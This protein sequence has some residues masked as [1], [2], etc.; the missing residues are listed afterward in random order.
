MTWCGIQEGPHPGV[1]WRLGRLRGRGCGSPLPS[2]GRSPSA[3]REGRGLR[4]SVWG[5]TN[6]GGVGGPEGGWKEGFEGFWYAG[7]NSLSG[8]AWCQ[9]LHICQAC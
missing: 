3:S 1:T 8:S 7:A 6:A 5:F 9:R 4:R 2:T